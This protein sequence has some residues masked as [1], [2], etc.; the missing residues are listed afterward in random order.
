[1]K[2]VM[3]LMQCRTL[4]AIHCRAAHL[5]VRRPARCDDRWVAREERIIRNL[6]PSSPRTVVLEHLLG[7]T[8]RAIGR[9]ASLLQVRRQAPRTT[10]RN[11]YG[12]YRAWSASEDAR[13]KTLYRRLSIV[14]IAV[15]LHRGIEAT[16]SRVDTLGLK[17]PIRIARRLMSLAILGKNK[18]KKRPDLAA[19][20]RAHPKRGRHNSFFGKRHSMATRVRLSRIARRK[21]TFQRLSKDPEFQ[22]KRLSALIL[23]PNKGERLL[24]RII[25]KACPGEYEYVGNGKALIDGLN[26]DWVSKNG[27]RIIELFGRTYHDPKQ[28]PWPVRER[29]TVRGRTAAFARMGYKTLIIWDSELYSLIRHDVLHPRLLNKI[30]GFTC[31]SP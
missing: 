11:Q 20:V 19:W 4:D 2:S 13:L 28:A 22:K 24:D 3:R 9:Q 6:Y 21:K 18:G 25:Q 26:P 29:G 14:A 15:R 1:M 30:R 12:L 27:K 7:R 17:R 5:R 23:K 31:E 10:I 8:W 16:K